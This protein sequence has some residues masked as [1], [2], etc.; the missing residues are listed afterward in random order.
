MEHIVSI[1]TPFIKLD[2]LLKFADIVQTGGEAK[3]II[4]DGAVSVNGEICQMRGK[5]CCPGDIVIVDGT[6]ISIT[7]DV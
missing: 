2:A 4:Q 6:T 5:K 3:I 1:K 7:G